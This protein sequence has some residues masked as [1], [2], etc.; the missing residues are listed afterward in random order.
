MTKQ[1]LCDESY[2]FVVTSSKPVSR[3]QVA[4]HLKMTKAPHMIRMLEDLTQMG[5]LSK[6][7]EEDEFGRNTWLYSAGNLHDPN[8]NR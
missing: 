7:M 6:K 8:C 2:K 3:L 1:T 5:Y 4:K